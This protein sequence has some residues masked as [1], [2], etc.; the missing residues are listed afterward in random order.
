MGLPMFRPDF[1]M[2]KYMLGDVMS[3]KWISV[4]DKSVVSGVE[5]N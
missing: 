4:N 2:Y 1:V 5:C 3:M